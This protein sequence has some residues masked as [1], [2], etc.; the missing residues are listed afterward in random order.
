M[1]LQMNLSGLWALGLTV[2]LAFSTTASSASDAVVGR[3]FD[4]LPPDW[5]IQGGAVAA[6]PLGNN[7]L[8]LASGPGPDDMPRLTTTKGVPLIPD[9]ELRIEFR[10]RTDVEGSGMHRGVWVYMQFLD[11]EGKA[12]KAESDG[13]AIPKS[14]AWN[15]FKGAMKVPPGA[16]LAQ[17]QIRI[18]Q[19]PG[20]FLDIDDLAMSCSPV[21]VAVSAD[22][23]H[24]P[25]LVVLASFVLQPDSSLKGSAGETLKNLSPP[26]VVPSFQLPEKYCGRPEF[27]Y[28][29]ATAFTAE[30]DTF[31]PE[32]FPAVFSLGSVFSGSDAN[33]MEA[34]FVGKGLMFRVR[35]ARNSGG[36][37]WS[38]P[39]DCAQGKTAVASA[40]LGRDELQASTG[41]L[42]KRVGSSTPFTWEKGRTFSLG[43]PGGAVRVQSFTLTVFKPGVM[44]A[45][46]KGQEA[47]LFHGSGPH[48]WGIAFP[49][50]GGQRANL[51]VVVTDVF[52]KTHAAP[53]LAFPTDTSDTAVTLTLP[54]LPYGWYEMKTR[55]ELDGHV[56]TL[57]RAFA[58]TP[59]LDLTVPAAASP[60]G[61]TQGF[62]LKGDSFS[63]A[64]VEQ[65]FRASAAAGN[66]WFRLWTVW[67]DVEREPGS[68][69]W[70]RMDQVVELALQNH[71]EL[72]VCLEGGNLPWQTS[73]EPGTP[74][75]TTYLSQYVPRDLGQ[76]S[77]FV[78]EFAS[79]YRGKVG[80]F[81]IGNESD[82]KEFFQPFSAESYL[83]FLKVGYQ[84]VKKGNPDAMVGLCGFA[85]AY[86]RLDSPK[87]K[88]GDRIFGAREFWDLK[89]E[90][91]YDIVDCHFY[92]LGTPNFYC[93]GYATMVPPFTE[94]LKKRGEG[95]KPLWN[96]ETGF[97]SGVK[98]ERGGYDPT[99]MI[100]DYEQACRLVEWHV[101]SQSVNVARSF[102]YLVTGTSGLFQGDFSPKPSCAASVNLSRMLPGMRFERALALPGGLFG[103][104]FSARKA[105]RQMT[106]LW[107]RGG[108]FPVAVSA[109]SGALVTQV[110]LFG[111]T[112]ELPVVN[113][114]SLVTVDEAPV[115]LVSS[116]PF[117]VASFISA[118]VELSSEFGKAKLRIGLLNPAQATLRVTLGAGFAGAVPAR[119]ELTLMS[120]EKREITLAPEQGEGNPTVDVKV[121]W[122]TTAAFSMVVPYTPRKLV[123]L[124][125][126]G[127]VELRI[128][129]PAQVKVGGETLD[130]QNH[131][132]STCQ[133]RGPTDS[134]AG[135]K[136]SREGSTLRFEILVT[137]DQ[138]I[139]IADRSPWNQDCV[140]LFY[141]L[142]DA[143]DTV[144]ERG[145]IGLRADGKVFPVGK[146][147][148]P[149]FHAKSEK[150]AAGY[151]VSGS[152]TLPEAALRRHCMLFDLS[153][154][155]ADGSDAGRRVQM[156][157]S[158]TENNHQN[159]D[160][161]GILALP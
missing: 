64:Y 53:A 89:P 34:A 30:T 142:L 130:N 25:E 42:W 132:L 48:T 108:G 129:Q 98:G 43:S 29:I 16:T 86:G 93:D 59:E 135:L 138:V 136:L 75:P 76:W 144:L 15:L 26:G 65:L 107:S 11:A 105:A 88:P 8:H 73:H 160:A 22:P 151:L 124:P 103:Y 70:S 24:N 87:M 94:F 2:V 50:G 143:A 68:R 62:S 161:Y 158:G 131:V 79:R 128:D 71:L 91:Y 67:D 61:I 72:Y 146:A 14:E 23:L 81:Q 120:G 90:P 101:Q 152:F 56:R 102:N 92:T 121:T 116:K 80:Y 58:V 1:I 115:Y 45:L 112:V 40:L 140:E 66:R 85:A 69:E 51:D 18:Q 106:V 104:C 3:T 149:D 148:L 57:V 52:G 156:V 38:F 60:L 134:S 137:D 133:W 55:I 17:A 37:E 39:V 99:P 139:T 82:T 111:N 126:G 49:E 84:A 114:V 127:Q 63:A 13:L 74:R 110:D 96:S 141:A 157:W 154:D 46:E 97:Q 153:V 119:E 83:R 125:S 145:Q 123:K 5:A 47:G 100:S 19:T 27:S 54:K 117:K 21:R 109:A 12:V 9:G 35:C 44:A 41:L 33:S 95:G 4:T 113:G 159:A 78:T 7:Y 6:E 147:A 155:D 118:K 20:K 32:S 36:M 31:G 77:E 122:E 150:T 10:Y 28:G